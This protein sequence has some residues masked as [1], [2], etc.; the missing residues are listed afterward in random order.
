MVVRSHKGQY[1]MIYDYLNELRISNPGSTTILMLDNRVFMRLYICL[2]ACKQGYK[3]VGVDAND[4]LYPI[5][6]DVV[7]AENQSA[8]Y[9]FL[10]LLATDL[11]IESNHNIT[12][13]LDKYKFI[14]KKQ[15]LMEALE[16]VFHSATHRTGVRHLYNNFKNSA[17]FK[18]KQLK[19]LLWKAARATYHKEFEDAMVELKVVSND[20]FNWLNGKDPSQWSKSHFSSFCKSDMLLSNLS[21]CFNKMI[22]KDRYK[23][24][25]TLMEMVRTKIMQKIAMKKEE[26]DKCWPTHAGGYNYQVSAGPSN[27]HAANLESQTCSCRKWD[28]TVIEPKLRRPPG[29]PKK[30][31]VKDLDEPSNSTGKFTKRGLQCNALSVAKQA[32]IKGHA[33]EKLVVTFL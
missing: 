5:A 9:W 19:D 23:P 22:L 2:A 4:S 30:K 33:R 7:E 29:R 12:F 26:A 20:A 8:W 16:E 21:E 14:I 15:G 6:Y 10:S 13:I 1:S 17:N 24:I 11:E 27:Q 3:S 32:I 25:L 31:R 28:I 18:G